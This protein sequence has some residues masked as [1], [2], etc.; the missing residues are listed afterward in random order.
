MKLK[1]TLNKFML[2]IIFKVLPLIQ[3]QPFKLFAPIVNKI[4][5]WYMQKRFPEQKA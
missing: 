2:K 1:K 3:Y 4:A 5:N